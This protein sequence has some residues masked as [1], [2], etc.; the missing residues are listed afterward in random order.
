MYG[1]R[2]MV[3][4]YYPICKEY[5][6]VVDNIL[7]CC[8]LSVKEIPEREIIKRESEGRESLHF[9]FRFL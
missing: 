5:A 8:D 2:M 4:H 6:F 3:K 7:Q 9:R 1:S